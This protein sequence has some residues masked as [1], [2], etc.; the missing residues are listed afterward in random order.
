MES[1][2][3]ERFPLPVLKV[4]S[5][6]SAGSAILAMFGGVAFISFLDALLTRGNERWLHRRGSVLGKVVSL[7]GGLAGL[8]LAGYTGWLL[9]VTNIPVW[10]TSPWLSALF[11]F[12]GISAMRGASTP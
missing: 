10:G 1:S 4:Y 6:M 11:V 5:P 8:A 2:A 3:S 7:V 9:N 12:S